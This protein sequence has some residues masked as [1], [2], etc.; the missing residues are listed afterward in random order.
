MS[1]TVENHFIGR[2]VF[3]NSENAKPIFLVQPYSGIY[4]SIVRFPY[5][6]IK[7]EL[8]RNEY[9]F[10]LMQDPLENLNLIKAVDNKKLDIFRNDMKYFY[11]QQKL[12]I[13]DRISPR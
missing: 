8:T 1:G 7:H 9:V 2:S 11:F 5:R 4:L 13:E 3:S 12:L 6:Y 10:N